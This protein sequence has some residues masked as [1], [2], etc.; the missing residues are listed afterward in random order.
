MFFLYNVALTTIA[1]LGLPFFLIK[2]T[3][4]PKYRAGLFQR[5]GC[6][7]RKATE[8][9][10]QAGTIWIHAVSVG[11][12]IAAV[13]LIRSLKHRYPEREILLTT[14][15]AT[16]NRTAKTQ[17]GDSVTVLFFPFDLLF[18]VQRVIQ[19]IRPSLFILM[20]TEIWPNCIRTLH[21][22]GIPILLVNG[23]I[24]RK[25]YSGYR[26]IRPMMKRVLSLIDAF[27][28]QTGKDAGRITRL[29]APENRVR[30]T[31]NIKFDQEIP[32]ISDPDR[33]KIR[34]EYALPDQGEIL[35][36]GSTHPGE[37]GPVLDAYA[38][39][40]QDIPDLILIL[41]P[42]HPERTPEIESLMRERNLGYQKRSRPDPGQRILLLDTVGEL[43]GLYR[44]GSV[45]F[46]GGSLVPKGGHNILEPAACGTPVVF[47]PHMENFP[48][49][50]RVIT[51]EGGG[52]QI[53]SSRE[54]ATVLGELFADEERRMKIGE[55][56]RRILLENRGAL[57]KTLELVD[58]FL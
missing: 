46:V 51:E 11:E 48:E 29:G 44:I 30:N 13:P 49:I 55:K 34:R 39:I 32:S 6:L 35:I 12:T 40:L 4:T 45:A 50:A 23:R 18:I 10:S 25:S 20:E 21:K 19:H 24:S 9:L 56:G 37:E 5:L 3:T 58:R 17:V 8:K 36:A 28:M 27:A 22:N 43:A 52:L 38:R 7:P 1:L 42:R 2:L 31:G 15:T 26:K 16:G 54:L 14:V 47:G 57:E 41:A 33:R 53:E